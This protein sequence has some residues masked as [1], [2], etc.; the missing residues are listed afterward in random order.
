MTSRADAQRQF[1]T[2]LNDCISLAVPPAG[3]VRSHRFDHSAALAHLTRFTF[4]PAFSK[5][6]RRALGT[7]IRDAGRKLDKQRNVWKRA[8]IVWDIFDALP[9]DWDDGALRH[10]TI[11]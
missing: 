11:G 6:A 4:S 3:D 7:A 9:D 1:L 10:P 5:E 2:A 8:R